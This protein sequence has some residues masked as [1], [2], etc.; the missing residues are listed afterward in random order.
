M[1]TAPIPP[2]LMAASEFEAISISWDSLAEGS[3]DVE[4][5]LQDF[6][7]YRIYRSTDNGVTWGDPLYNNLGELVSWQPYLQFDLDNDISGPDPAAPWFNLGDNTGL[8]YNFIDSDPI[9][10]LFINI[11]SPESIIVVD[12][13]NNI[14]PPDSNLISSPKFD[15]ARLETKVFYHA[16]APHVP[17]D[18]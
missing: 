6:E 13:N 11:L 9:P 5:E 14:S 10:S 2:D 4:T 8:S 15:V 12:P 16:N 7:G 3:I 18:T 1:F 17:V